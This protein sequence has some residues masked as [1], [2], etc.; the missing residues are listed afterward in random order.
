MRILILL[1]LFFPNIFF[2][3]IVNSTEKSGAS[4]IYNDA[5][6]RYLNYNTQCGNVMY[7]TLFF[8]DDILLSDS[9]LLTK[10]KVPLV[11]LPL[12]EIHKK[13]TSETNFILHRLYPIQVKNGVFTVGLVP[14]IVHKAGDELTFS[15]PGSFII[16]YTYDNGR[17]QFKYLR[18]RSSRL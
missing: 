15:N 12:E 17:K 4:N 2:G 7:D 10:Q 5:I 9:I 3:Q 11:S 18:Q 13:L 1:T 8:W 16:D 6:K 14:F